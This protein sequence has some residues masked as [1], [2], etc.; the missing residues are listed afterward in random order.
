MNW[1]YQSRPKVI[2]AFQW[3]SENTIVP[4]WAR[5]CFTQGIM[6]YGQ[7][8]AGQH[9]VISTPTG[10]A[11]ARSGDYIIKGI[12]EG[13]F[14]PCPQDVF[15]ASYAMPEIN[16]GTGIFVADDGQVIPREAQIEV[17]HEH[18]ESF[19]QL[20]DTK[21]LPELQDMVDLMR[22]AVPCEQFQV[23]SMDVESLRNHITDFIEKGAR[24]PFK[25]IP[26]SETEIKPD[27]FDAETMMETPGPIISEHWDEDVDANARA[28]MKADL[29]DAEKE[30]MEEKSVKLKW[31]SDQ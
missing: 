12:K 13:D 3:R 7:S 17:M 25:D 26:L 10:E 15:T 9:V 11:I 30:Y 5:E 29:E 20:L 4:E 27:E 22:D 16:D 8:V 28:E 18:H 19:V 21:L 31:A 1:Q 14:Y 24:A 23:M 2:E 6:Q